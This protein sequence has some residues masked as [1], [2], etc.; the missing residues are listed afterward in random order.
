M[1]ADKIAD[2]LSRYPLTGRFLMGRARHA[3]SAAE[4]ALIEGLVERT[5]H[6]HGPQ[7]V[8]ERGRRLDVSTVLIEGTAARVMERKRGRH[9][10]AL[11]LPGDFFDLHAYALKR[12]DHDIVT[13]GAARLGFVRHERISE[14][15][16]TE[17][18]LARLLWFSTLLDAAI[19]REWIVRLEE[20]T[21]EGRL[22]NL[23][24]EIWHRLELV[25]LGEADGFDLPLNQIELSNACG[26]TTVHMNRTVRTLRER[27]I[28][29]I[30][31]GRVIVP[32]RARLE[33]LGG[34][35][36][37]YLYGEGELNV[38]DELAT[39]A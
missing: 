15:L 8:L 18:H 19:H 2:E 37:A 34:F 7:T 29:E 36:P 35:D 38:G 14:I 17:P 32:N 12:L 25:G 22:A 11:H 13:I 20:L 39:E 16:R 1:S 26:T 33:Q 23:L 31:R 30:R 9:I 3:M 27:G 10:V 21:A 4:K 5:E 24:A 6:F 28:A